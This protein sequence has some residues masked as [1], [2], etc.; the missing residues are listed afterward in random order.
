M[1]AGYA[2]PAFALAAL[3]LPLFTYLTPFYE[4]ERGVDLAALGLAWIAIR[5]FDA[6]S[7]PAIGWLSDRTPPAWGRRRVWL[8]V[9]V[10]VIVFATWQAFVPPADA[11]LGH[12]VLWL[13]I[14][15][16]GWT[17]AQTPYAAWG[18]EIA[19]GYHDRSRVTAWREAVA[20]GG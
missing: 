9:S 7:D 5:L 4:T 17:M 11:G 3:Y 16:L 13:F 1:L 20:C 14:L 2:L 18:A 6:V 15:T 12:A 19:T 8:A 10:P